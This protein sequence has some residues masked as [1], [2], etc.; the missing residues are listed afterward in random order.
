MQSSRHWPASGLGKFIK[1]F[2]KQ[3]ELDVD[4]RGDHYG[5]FIK[6]L[7]KKLEGAD[8]PMERT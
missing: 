5:H 8:Y 2:V 1:L 4:L 3:R 7:M 6:L